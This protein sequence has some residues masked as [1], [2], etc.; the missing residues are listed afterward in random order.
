MKVQAALSAPVRGQAG[1]LVGK[2]EKQG[3]IDTG[4]EI[5]SAIQIAFPESLHLHI[6][7]NHEQII[8]YIVGYMDEYVPLSDGLVSSDVIVGAYCNLVADQELLIVYTGHG[9]SAGMKAE[10]ESAKSAG[11]EIFEFTDWNEHAK[12]RLARVIAELKGE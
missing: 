2:V 6:P 8:E 5:G 9:I 3:N 4:K 11:V 10:M 7:H 12:E 1:D